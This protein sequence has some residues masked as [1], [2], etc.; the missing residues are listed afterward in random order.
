MGMIGISPAHVLPAY[1]LPS[2]HMQMQMQ[3]QLRWVAQ[4][5][6]DA[7]TCRANRKR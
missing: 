4:V 7:C 1:A 3:M 2:M 6:G 5:A